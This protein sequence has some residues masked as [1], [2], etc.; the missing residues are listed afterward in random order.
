MKK[1]LTIA[2]VIAFAAS[3][4]FAWDGGLAGATNYKI[5][6]GLKNWLRNGAPGTALNPS[7]TLPVSDKVKVG[8][9]LTIENN[10]SELTKTPADK[11]SLSTVAQKTYTK[12]VDK[13]N[14]GIGVPLEMI[15]ISLDIGGGANYTADGT[16]SLSTNGGLKN[17]SYFDYKET[18]DDKK[19]TGGATF[20][21]GTTQSSSY[22]AS[23]NN[24]GGVINLYLFLS[25][26]KLPINNLAIEQKFDIGFG[27]GG[28][29][30]PAYSLS[31]AGQ[32]F[33]GILTPVSSRYYFAT[34]KKTYDY[35]NTVGVVTGRSDDNTEIKF[36]NFAY[37]GKFASGVN[38]HEKLNLDI[39][40][41]TLSFE[42]GYNVGLTSWYTTNIFNPLAASGNVTSSYT[43]VGKEDLFG[44]KPLK[45]N[46][47]FYVQLSLDIN[48]SATT[49][50]NVFVKEALGVSYIG[51]KYKMPSDYRYVATSAT[52]N[53]LGRFGLDFQ[54]ETET[55]ITNTVTVGASFKQSFAAPGTA[56]LPFIPYFKLA[57]EWYINYS[58]TTGDYYDYAS[59][60]SGAWKDT[61][62]DYKQ[63]TSTAFSATS[64]NAAVELGFNFNNFSVSLTWKPTVTYGYFYTVDGDGYI[65]TRTADPS[66]TNLWNLANWAFSGACEFPPPKAK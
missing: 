52:G 28:L 18:T 7:I 50:N 26:K 29:D 8:I 57:A 3:M 1:I 2:I 14:I 40:K 25:V 33:Q 6:F 11:S 39:A 66:D 42:I 47:G 32:V 54:K 53:G 65:K 48:P 36:I 30:L 60:N 24:G 20:V 62:Y 15:D 51:W 44:E 49:E 34:A 41:L 12:L 4:S 61:R 16:T 31:N 63:K 38:L 17:Y 13:I 23:V 37:N 9:T 46:G 27:D 45:V 35:I 58:Y 55:T 21:N 10:G 59:N 22:T 64:G 56:G 5:D 19:V 43:A